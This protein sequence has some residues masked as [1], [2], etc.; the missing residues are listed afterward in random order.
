M[1]GSSRRDPLQQTVLLRC[2]IVRSH[3]RESSS[4]PTTH[5]SAI[6]RSP[7][8]L[9]DREAARPTRPPYVLRAR[10]RD[11]DDSDAANVN[12]TPRDLRA[13][14]FLRHIAGFA[15]HPSS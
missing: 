14:G 15:D 3:G 1:K 11:K 10:P 6:P 5:V 7:E 9:K 13:D 4:A 2:A 12:S 8:M